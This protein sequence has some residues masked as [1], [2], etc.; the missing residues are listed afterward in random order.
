MK[1]GDDEACESFLSYAKVS[2]LACP[3]SGRVG[4]CGSD[5]ELAGK[6]LPKLSCD[7]YC[8]RFC[9]SHGRAGDELFGERSGDDERTFRAVFLS[10]IM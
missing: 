1:L 4:L 2:A 3:V 6:L 8:V 9:C 5:N 7:G 10:L